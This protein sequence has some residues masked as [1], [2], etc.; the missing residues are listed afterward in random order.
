MPSGVGIVFPVVE[1][2]QG[3][4]IGRERAGQ[5]EREGPP[6]LNG[7]T[8]YPA[9]VRVLAELEDAK[10]SEGR[11]RVIEQMVGR[12]AEVL[13]DQ[14]STNVVRRQMLKVGQDRLGMIERYLDDPTVDTGKRIGVLMKL[15]EIGIRVP[16][17][18][19]EVEGGREKTFKVRVGGGGG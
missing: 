17:G 9:E 12:V 4:P 2:G 14:A 19:V 11:A 5:S 16:T 8:A 15:L 13:D 3:P 7:R 18:T 1:I 10:G 6:V